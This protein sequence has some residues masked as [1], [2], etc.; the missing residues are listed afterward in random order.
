MRRTIGIVLAA[1]LAVGVVVAVV[2]SLG[3]G[4]NKA[5][6]QKVVVVKGVIGSEKQ[7]FFQDRRVQAEFRKHGL[8]VVVD[9]A[10]SRSIATTVD[11]SKYDFAFPSGVPAA[12]QI[13][14]KSGASTTYTE[15]Y[16]PMVIASWQPIVKILEAAGVAQNHGTY[17]TFNVQKYLDLVKANKRWIDLPGA[18]TAYPATKSVLITSTDV[19]TSNSAANYLSIASYVA[20]GNN[21]V[22]NDSQGNAIIDQVAPLFL[23]Q[24]FTATSSE[25]P[26]DDYLAIG[27]GKAPIVFIYEAQFLQHVFA[28]DGSITGQMR[29]MYPDPDVYSKHVIVPLDA[30]GD[31]VGRLL[32]NDPVL[33]QLAA[34]YGFRTNDPKYFN[35]LVQQHHAQVDPSIVD[36]IEPPSYEALENMIEKI[37]QLYAQ[38]QGGGATP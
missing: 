11:L 26:F 5:P 17:D 8:R 14:T 25:E 37:E 34:Q 13:K 28:N 3:G 23:R 2:L 27:I 36:V 18:N 30:N 6:D 33:Q 21:V 32:L 31:K 7:P 20:N 15:F 22:E 1:V 29:L 4:G 16:T 12:S 35:S 19:R 38:N 24:G 10:G 9:T